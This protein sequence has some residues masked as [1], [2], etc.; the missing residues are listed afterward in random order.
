M[1]D[2][3]DDKVTWFSAAAVSTTC[4][5]LATAALAKPE[6]QNMTLMIIIKILQ[7]AATSFLPPGLNSITQGI[8]GVAG[9]T[10]QVAN[11]E[12]MNHLGTVV[13]ALASSLLSM[14]LFP[15]LGLLFL[16][17]PV[18]CA[19]LLFFLCKLDPNWIDH[20]EARGLTAIQRAKTDDLSSCFNNGKRIEYIPPTPSTTEKT[21]PLSPAEMLEAAQQNVRKPVEKTP[22]FNFGCMDG[23]ALEVVAPWADGSTV[24]FLKADSPL[25][26]LCDPVLLIFILI[27]FGF[28]LANATV[29]PLVMQT[30]A[31]GSGAG[32][33]YLAGMCMVVSQ[34]FM[35]LSAKLC[36]KYSTTY[37]RKPLFLIGLVSLPVRCSLL[38]LL[39]KLRGDD[40]DQSL[41]L[42]N[43]LILSTQALGGIGLG[44]FGTMYI[45]VTSDISGGTGR[46]SMT[47]GLTTAAISI[48]C[49]VSGYVGE[50][51][52][53]DLGYQQVFG[54]LSALSWVPPLLYLVAMPETLPPL[55]QTKSCDEADV[56]S[57]TSPLNRQLEI[58]STP[59]IDEEDENE[60]EE[61]ANPQSTDYCRL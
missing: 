37:G 11:N 22:S 55:L 23:T 57:K 15:D 2:Y 9:M 38:A 5:T 43:C 32:G 26:V 42:M 31:I 36:G 59:T 34:S 6:G 47:L 17:A 40:K 53:Q 35:A 19:G 51:L 58:N 39:L 21:G 25:R 18:A 61:M 16:V 10:N 54:I 60:E 56:D 27:V 44:V 29:L 33:M 13:L 48:G 7:G 46:F 45:L 4:L 12:M 49:T 20:N 30:L 24:T 41:G 52:A 14:W 3:S 50:A 28:N 8:V 1:Y